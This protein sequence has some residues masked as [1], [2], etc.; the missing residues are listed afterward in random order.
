MEEQ[1][2]Q[3][4]NIKTVNF[5]SAFHCQNENANIV[6]LENKE[7]TNNDDDDDSSHDYVSFIESLSPEELADM[8]EI[9]HRFFD[10]YIAEYAIEMSDPDFKHN[11]CVQ[12]AG[13]L[14]H[15]MRWL[16]LCDATHIPELREWAEEQCELFY[17]IA[18]I[19]ERQTDLSH[20]PEYSPSLLEY[21]NLVSSQKQTEQRTDA[22]Y[23]ERDNMITA[24]AAWK[25]FASDAQR[26]S[27]IYEKCQAVAY[28][29]KGT[30]ISA[31]TGPN[32]LQWG[33]K[34]EPVSRE[35]YCL[36]HPEYGQVKEY[37][38]IPHREYKY[39]GASPDGITET[40]RMLEIKNIVNREITGEPLEAYW[41]QMQIQMEVC[42]LP[43]CDFVETRFKEF[44]SE[45]AFLES[46]HEIKGVILQFV[47]RVNVLTGESTGSP[48]YV[49]I[50]LHS[51]PSPDCQGGQSLTIMNKQVVD[52]WIKEQQKQR[53]D[54]VLYYTF[55]WYL[56]EYS[57]CVVER[58]RVWF[59]AAMPEIE[60]CW[61][62]IVK[63]REEGYGHR[64]PQSKRS[65]ASILAQ[66]VLDANTNTDL[67]SPDCQ[68]GQSLTHQINCVMPN[69]FISIVK[70]DS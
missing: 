42:D 21:V 59:E 47:P 43:V 18:D 52:V 27:L 16:D 17:A 28:G 19:P 5:M 12:L 54:S 65:M 23:A 53:P 70:L 15:E 9:A 38:C 8:E 57:E 2:E 44:D 46:D 69:N 66:T 49:Y 3:E 10:D 48:E 36:R 61:N 25:I 22:W 34:Y 51:S 58:N 7:N 41:I 62:T 37:G 63:E 45:R 39:L 11:M 13:D 40:G 31:G 24:S 67:T 56:D 29:Q 20:S 55:Y 35:L 6:F 50:P 60:D 14:Y 26:N 1:I 4:T 32:S 64:A 33:T 68:G 30:R